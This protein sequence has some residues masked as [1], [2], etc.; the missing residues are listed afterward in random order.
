MGL[1]S[2]HQAGYMELDGAT[3]DADCERVDVHGGVSKQL[4]C[5][6]LFEHE[7]SRPKQFRCG[8]CEY[9]RSRGGLGARLRAK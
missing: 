8:T 3:K 6:N 2:S 1:V 4:G 9:V 5:C 7:D